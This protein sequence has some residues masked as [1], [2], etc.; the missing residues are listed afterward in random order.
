MKPNCRARRND[1]HHCSI[2]M[3]SATFVSFGWMTDLFRQQ[4]RR[5]PRLPG[6]HKGHYGAP[7]QSR[8]AVST[9]RDRIVT[10]V[11]AAGPGMTRRA[12]EMGGI[13][14]AAGRFAL[15]SLAF[16]RAAGEL[17]TAV[18]AEDAVDA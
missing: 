16:G 5:L 6:N 13:F 18:S 1:C 17:N 14:L 9:R 8:R 3:Q 15:A 10:P 2:V 12:A 4:T 7:L 11:S